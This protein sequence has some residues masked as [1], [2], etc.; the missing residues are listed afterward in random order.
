MLSSIAS[1]KKGMCLI[2]SDASSSAEETC[3]AWN[4]AIYKFKN[5]MADSDMRS[6]K[7][8]SYNN[9]TEFRVG[10]SPSHSAFIDLESKELGYYDDDKEVNRV[11]AKLFSLIGLDCKVYD[12][13]V[14]CSGLDEEKAREAAKI[15][16]AAT[17]MDMRMEDPLA[18]WEER[19]VEKCLEERLNKKLYYSS[20]KM[21]TAVPPLSPDEKVELEFCLVRGRL[22]L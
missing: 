6:L 20:K 3:I 11:M 2:G 16:S 4:K 12:W 18:F 17:S 22:G 7:G 14:L 9:R 19:E 10:S 15:L 8:I 13:I 1:K 5:L 21:R